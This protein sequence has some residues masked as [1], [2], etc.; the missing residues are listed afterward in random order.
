[1]ADYW[2]VKFFEEYKIPLTA[3]VDHLFASSEETQSDEAGKV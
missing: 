3:F 1:L 2:K